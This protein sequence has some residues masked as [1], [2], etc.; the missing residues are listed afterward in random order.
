M[1]EG[2]YSK[3]TLGEGN[4]NLVIDD[5]G[6]KIK[7]TLGIL[8]LDYGE[9]EIYLKVWF[10]DFSTE[11]VISESIIINHPKP[12]VESIEYINLDPVQLYNYFN[13][14][15]EIYN[16]KVDFQ[17]KVNYNDSLS[18]DEKIKMELY[19]TY[20][21][22]VTQITE[23]T[24][25]P[26]SSLTIIPDTSTIFPDDDIYSFQLAIN[27]FD[28]HKFKIRAW[29]DEPFTQTGDTLTSDSL[30]LTY[31]A[32]TPPEIEFTTL[33]D[34]IYTD[35]NNT[36]IHG[37]VTD[38][39]GIVDSV[40]VDINGTI[41]QAT[42]LAPPQQSPEIFPF[43]I[44][45]DLDRPI[46]QIYAWAKDTVNFY[47]QGGLVSNVDFTRMVYAYLDNSNPDVYLP[48]D[49]VFT[50]V[51]HPP[52]GQF[53][54]PG[55]I[56]QAGRFIPADAE[57]NVL[58]TISY[59]ISTT[60]DSKTLD[61]EV[62]V[63]EKYN[64]NYLDEDQI[65][66]KNSKDWY[67][68]LCN[69]GDY[70]SSWNPVGGIIEKQVGDS[71]YVE[72][73]EPSSGGFQ[74]RIEAVI[75]SEGFGYTYTTTQLV[76]VDDGFAPEK[77]MIRMEGNQTDGYMLFSSVSDTENYDYEWF[78]GQASI[79][80]TWNRPYIYLPEL[81]IGDYVY[82]VKVTDKFTKAATESYHYPPGDGS[83]GKSGSKSGNG[84]I[85]KSNKQND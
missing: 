29:F 64:I 43:K 84:L 44:S 6:E 4:T 76:A 30:M 11:P 5:N 71:V 85:N 19:H 33:F 81:N 66:W 48:K 12:I 2:E 24:I 1:L 72:W 56:S 47:P 39:T 74:T 80:S 77:A 57:N 65:F 28:F 10:C 75:G 78:K 49:S 16:P 38:T 27:D 23:T 53:N 55:I 59:E 51:A 25:Y 34:T 22:S 17:V 82:Y 37:I 79:D 45:V 69:E 67:W 62:F 54:G 13:Q 20:Y 61:Y 36:L 3:A 21:N 40:W 52:G 26:G 8:G 46:N 42:L 35:P 32:N 63:K 41:L 68:V 18:Q 15:T 9:N 83:T 70:I 14:E 31:R 58:N 73:T 7:V 50:I 60:T